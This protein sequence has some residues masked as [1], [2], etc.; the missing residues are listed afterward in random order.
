M[1]KRA[2]AVIT[3]L[4]I[5]ILALASCNG[6]RAVQRMTV[7]EGLKT[8]YSKDEVPDFS[9]LKVLVEY[10]D[11]S[12]EEVTGD[13]LSVT[14]LNT[15]VIGE[16]V[17]NI[18]YNGYTISVSVTVGGTHAPTESYFVTSASLPDRLALW[19]SNKT[20]FIN[21]DHLYS[22]GDDNGFIFTLKL[23]AFTASGDKISVTKYTSASTVSLLGEETPLS[24]E[25]LARY[26]TIDEEKNSF[27][28][29]EEAIGKSFTISTRPKDKLTG[30]EEDFT[31]S[32]DITV[33][34][35]YNIY[36]AYEL[37]Y[38]TN[39]ISLAFVDVDP[40]ETRGQPEIV[41]DF[42]KNEKGVDMPEGISS[43]VLHDNMTLEVT[44]LP[45]EY[46]YQKNRQND[47]YEYISLFCHENSEG[48][49]SLT[50]H[51]NYFA[52]YT[53]KLPGVVA[54][55]VGNQDNAVSNANLFYFGVNAEMGRDYDFDR[56]STTIKN[57][58]L[59][60]A[61]PKS[62]NETTS[63]DSMLGLAAVMS[64]YQ[65]MNVENANITSFFI[66]I[67]A[68]YDYQIVN[69]T[70]SNLHSAWQNHINL[71]SENFHQSPDDEPLPKD[72][73]PRLTLNISKSVLTQCGG[74]AIIA[75]TTLPTENRHKHSGVV[76]NVSEDSTVESWVT[77]EEAWFKAFGLASIATKIKE[78]DKP[79]TKDLGS[80]F[81][82]E[83]IR[84]VDGKQ[85]TFRV[86]N[87]VMVNIMVL[88]ISQD[89]N[90]LL[91]EVLLGASDVD[92][93]FNV[94]DRTVLDMD[95]YIVDGKHQSYGNT[96]VNDIKNK[97][98][99][100]G[101]FETPDGSVAY[102]SNGLK[103]TKGDITASDENDYLA[104]YYGGMGFVFGDYHKLIG[105]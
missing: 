35:G 96:A 13:K 43:L 88:D 16:S 44:D 26:V 47:F 22:V 72:E 76:V 34:N 4:L 32:I 48:S 8:E 46:F 14:G 98:K 74:P 24:G 99:A 1:K 5:L 37:N 39:A 6:D 90:T 31:K 105:R 3:A 53:H 91:N 55:G 11:G 28:F 89:V 20:D 67:I 15:G 80:S 78:F 54:Q 73:Y 18:S 68:D 64:R 40:S 57:L 77:G 100:T 12:S 17:V 82:K 23:D 52:I 29:T 10:N 66:S 19:E 102:L 93:I 97:N 30:D 81:I 2:L 62:D 70:E 51:G 104:F 94:G 38:L 50:I 71:R 61:D 75:C 21:K 60:G 36:K 83:E 33:V 84:M 49:E 45:V 27:D 58:M 56:Y 92:G 41:R 9:A 59:A 25:E 85:Q 79:L 7:L 69:I 87:F 86:V 65:V 103:T 101:V 42:L 63:K 95:D